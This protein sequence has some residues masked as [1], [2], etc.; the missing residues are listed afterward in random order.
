[1]LKLN[2]KCLCEYCFKEIKSNG[3]CNCKKDSLI[4]QA[5]ELNT[6]LHGRFVIG[7]V[8]GK[9]GFGFTYLAYDSKKDTVVAIKEFFPEALVFRK[10]G[11]TK[12][13]L[14]DKSKVE[15]YLKSLN[16]F[17]EE[18]KVISTLSHPNIVKVFNMYY[19]NDTAYFT[20]EYLNGSD[21]RKYVIRNG[22][23]LSEN[24][25]LI[26][27]AAVS[28]ALET[29]HTRGVLHRDVA[30]DNIFITED[31]HVKLIDFGSARNY[32][33]KH[34]DGMTVMLKKSFAPI[35]QYMKSGDQGPWTDIYA[36]GATM[37]YCLN[38]NTPPDALT[39][40]NN[41]ELIINCSP[42]LSGIIKKMMCVQK[43]GRFL[44]IREL[45]PELFRAFTI[46][47]EP[48]TFLTE[49]FIASEIPDN[50]AD[51]EK[52]GF[53]SSFKKTLFKII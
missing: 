29:L 15:I 9:G 26:F 25:C 46:T 50:K 43:D 5:L 22:G 28:E 36:L 47:A 38:G 21:L 37:I 33:D 44:S 1:M 30:P 31:G 49:P 24:E 8:L 14:L 41:S 35:E 32:I 16:R 6:I 20:M 3:K 2:N 11:E 12:I 39:R 42:Y 34:A 40:I 10:S 51:Q 23:K 45:K 7:K 53:W 17:Y 13:S 19:E 52:P 4:P 18:A 48:K 27:T